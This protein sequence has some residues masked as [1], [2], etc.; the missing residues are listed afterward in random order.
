MQD[1]LSGSAPAQQ[2]ELVK[3]SCRMQLRY[4]VENP[5]GW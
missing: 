2:D 5:D 3:L 4:W 1:L